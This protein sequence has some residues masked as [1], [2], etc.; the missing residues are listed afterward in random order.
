[1]HSIPS[2]LGLQVVAFHLDGE[3]ESRYEW[4]DCNRSLKT[5]KKFLADL[6][7]RFESSIYD[8]PLGRIS[9]LT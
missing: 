5:W 9:K 6:Q 3:A 4:M 7:E 8:D 1:M 2:E